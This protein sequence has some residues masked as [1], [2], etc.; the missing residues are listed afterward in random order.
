MSRMR[1][2]VLDDILAA[3]IPPSAKVVATYLWNRANGQGVC[4]PSIATIATNC[5]RS[6]SSVQRAIKSLSQKRVDCR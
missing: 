6:R 2:E 1:Y 3:D 4:W 5:R